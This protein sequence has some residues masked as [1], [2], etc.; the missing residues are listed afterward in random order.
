MWQVRPRHYHTV[1][2][3]TILYH[4]VPYCTMPY[5]TVPYC[6]EKE[7]TWHVRPCHPDLHLP[8]VSNFLPGT[9]FCQEGAACTHC[10]HA[11]SCLFL[12]HVPKRSCLFL[13]WPWR[14]SSWTWRP[15]RASSSRSQWPCSPRPQSRGS[16]LRPRRVPT[17]QWA[18]SRP[19][20][21]RTTRR[22]RGSRSGG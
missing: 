14:C 3:R 10:E 12:D 6:I 1:P 2:C 5:H 11:C 16:T 21:C 22:G 13:R 19:T 15:R 9:W 7:T 8:E 18:R 17:S 4:A 20:R